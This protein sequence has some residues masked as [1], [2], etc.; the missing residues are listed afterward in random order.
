MVFALSLAAAAFYPVASVLQHRAAS[1]APNEL[2]MRLALL[3]R[4]IRRPLWLCGIATDFGGYVFEAAALAVG[5][6]ALVEPLIVLGLP[7]AL[8]I[9]GIWAKRPLRRRDWA[10]IAAVTVGIAVF[11]AVTAP[12]RG[13]DVAPGTHWAVAGAVAF[14]VAGAILAA[15]RRLPRWRATLYGTATGTVQAFTAALTK[16]AA[17]LFKDHGFGALTH[18]E[19][20]ALVFTG[21]LGMVM[22]QSSYQ[23]G[24]LR[25]SLP[26]LTLTPPL[27]SVLFAVTVFSEDIGS[28]AL[29]LIVALV[30]AGVAA[31]GVIT[32]GHSELVE[33]AYDT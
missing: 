27:V 17:S 29:T 5:S 23:A 33:V 21:L 30:S 24:E 8:V 18:W 15:A 16:S 3:T 2:S 11:V 12:S 31:A 20:Y 6:L 7:L 9:G 14:V 10:G 4:L 13:N 19:P 1:E 25:A 22:A 28:G 26:A 32:L